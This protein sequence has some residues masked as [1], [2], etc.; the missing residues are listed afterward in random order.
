MEPS[1]QQSVVIREAPMTTEQRLE[2]LER[3]NKWM[4]RVGAVGVAV[5]AAVVLMG[6]EKAESLPDLEVR[7]LRLKD[8]DGKVRAMLSLGLLGSPSL[9]LHAKDGM[10]RASLRVSSDGW[11]IL[12]LWHKRVLHAALGSSSR[13]RTADCAPHFRRPPTAR[14]P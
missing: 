2:R 14:R 9:S 4:R 8:K 1:P 12:S 6:Q 5:V 3:E 10:P 13:T 11:P 7:S